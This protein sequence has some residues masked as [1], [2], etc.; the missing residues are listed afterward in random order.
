MPGKH[1]KIGLPRDFI[2][3]SIIN[4]T[5]CSI[6]TG[7]G[8]FLYDTQKGAITRHILQGKVINGV[9]QDREGNTWLLTAGAGI[10]RIGSFEFMNYTFS[11]N[12][13]DN[14][15]I[16]SLNK[17]DS[18]LYAGSDKSWLFTINHP[19]RQVRSY[20]IFKD[21]INLRILSLLQLPSKTI[22]LGTNYGVYT[23]SGKEW[24]KSRAL[25]VKS[26]Q[27]EG[28]TVFIS[29]HRG[30][31]KIPKEHSY[32]NFWMNQRSTCSYKQGLVYY[33]G[34]LNGLYLRDS[35]GQD[36]WLG[37]KEPLLR[38][39]I[40]DLEGAPDGMLWIATHGDGVIGYKN[41]KILHSIRQKDGLTSDICRNLFIAGRE[42]W[43]GTDKGLNRLQWH[44]DA[45]KITTF[46]SADGLLSDITY[47]IHVEDSQVYIGTPAGLTTFDANKISLQSFCTLRITD[48]HA[49]G[50]RW[51]YDTSGFTLLPTNNAIRFD[52]V[53][54]SYRSAGDITYQYRLLGL[55]DNWQSTRKPFL[56]TCPCLR[57][58]TNFKYGL[59]TNLEYKVI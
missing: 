28:D 44:K 46:A 17:F 6:N 38:G 10:F 26:M 43:V 15:A 4:D 7:N 22:L 32:L 2:N 54:I 20:S 5:L 53:G 34:T 31:V 19:N 8:A 16:Y 39:R 33:N 47:A 51:A 42:V 52:F 12:Q 36:S 23:T 11:K 41:G 40:M 3:L 59:P 58:N 35:L 56:I 27:L 21:E 13:K 55:N 14:Q 9:F 49:A 50:T 29:T 48:I 25:S 37:E 24:G 1:K 45:Y 57:A 18:L 30:L